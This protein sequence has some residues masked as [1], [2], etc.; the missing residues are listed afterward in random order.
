MQKSTEGQN[1]QNGWQLKYNEPDKKIFLKLENGFETCTTLSDCIIDADYIETF[2]CFENLEILEDLMKEF[3]DLK[4]EKRAGYVSGLCS[5]KIK[6]P[7][8]LS[9]R[10]LIMHTTGIADYKNKG[11]LLISKS[12]APG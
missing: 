4:W 3:Y 5:T 7:W 6:M 9:D 11:V 8:P 12:I 2:A 1:P 10:M